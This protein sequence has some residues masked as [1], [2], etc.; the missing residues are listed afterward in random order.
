MNLVSGVKTAQVVAVGDMNEALPVQIRLLP[1]WSGK[2]KKPGRVL[3]HD[4]QV[5]GRD[6]AELDWIWRWNS[7]NL[8]NKT[9]R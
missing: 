2:K 1:K 7:L 6:S 3:T 5:E 8:F 9:L 4:E